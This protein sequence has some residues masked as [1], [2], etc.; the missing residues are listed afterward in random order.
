MR[1]VFWQ[2]CLSPHQLP[3]IVRLMDDERVDEVIVIAG[4][5]VSDERKKMGWSVAQY[6]GVERCKI[7]VAP[8]DDIV[9][10]LMECRQKDSWHLFSG[11][12]ADAFVFKCLQ[13]SLSYHLRR[14]IV[15]ERPN[16]YD[17]KHNIPNA[18]PYWMHKLR[19]MLQDKK[20]A[21]HIE[22][23][24]AMGQEAVAYFQ[25]LHMVWKVFPFCYCT[26]SAKVGAKPLQ[27]DRLPQYLYCGSLSARKDP[28][29]IARGLSWLNKES[30]HGKLK[31]IGDGPMRSKIEKYVAIH[32]LE[33]KILL[34]GTKRQ[35]EVP[36]YMQQADIFILPSLYD[37]WGA[38]INEALQAGCY[39]ICSDACGASDLICEDSKLGVVF[40]HGEYKQLA[41]AIA[42]CEKN[43]EKIRKNRMYRQE[44]AEKH[45][46]GKAVAKYFV[47]CLH[48]EYVAPIW[49]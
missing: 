3:Y 8:S 35:T 32:N 47:D 39:V 43:I 4:E 36:T 25:S 13:I 30:I 11:I 19:F 27:A 12:R 46:S 34:L 26:L 41:N 23:V 44:W 49:R 29:A 28:L 16:T 18:K 15:T 33:G 48:G 10:Q 40:A 31:M 45:I 37:G 17:F 9:R 20:Y 21:K 2:N 5:S 1:I 38:V 24:F 7:Y 42:W 22:V 6:E 14:G